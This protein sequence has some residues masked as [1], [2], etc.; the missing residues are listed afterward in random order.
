M[1]ATRSLVR[2]ISRGANW[3]VPVVVRL[4]AARRHLLTKLCGPAI[5]LSGVQT[6]HWR[7][8]GRRD[9]P[10]MVP[11]GTLLA[12]DS[13]TTEI[14]QWFAVRPGRRSVRCSHA[15]V[16]AISFRSA[17]RL[18]KAVP[19]GASSIFHSVILSGGFPAKVAAK[20]CR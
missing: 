1:T 13:K 15:G 5:D 4:A 7:R 12:A 2:P 14:L 9:G 18:K 11:H 19:A 17:D 8:Y 3:S 16:S 10:L 6:P 20:H